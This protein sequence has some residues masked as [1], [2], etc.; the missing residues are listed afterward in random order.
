MDTS[1]EFYISLFSICRLCCGG[2]SCWSAAWQPLV[3]LSLAVVTDLSPV[4]IIPPVL[5]AHNLHPLSSWQSHAKRSNS[6]PWLRGY[7]FRFQKGDQSWPI[8]TNHSIPRRIWR[9]HLKHLV[10]HQR[11]GLIPLS[12][13]LNLFINK[14][15]CAYKWKTHKNHIIHHKW[16]QG[17]SSET[18]TIRS[19]AATKSPEEPIKQRTAKTSQGLRAALRIRLKPWLVNI[20][21][22]MVDPTRACSGV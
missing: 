5:K 13:P 19:Q 7:A 1:I 21:G 8:M 16:T 20:G 22:P 4:G 14:C 15:V 17:I 12:N 2:K 10:S 9:M 6:A 3:F 11:S 18:T